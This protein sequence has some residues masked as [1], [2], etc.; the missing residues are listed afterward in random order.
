[1]P[2]PIAAGSPRSFE[3]LWYGTNLTPNMGIEFEIIT[4]RIIA[5]W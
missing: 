4:E 2:A 5:D 3:L 1:M